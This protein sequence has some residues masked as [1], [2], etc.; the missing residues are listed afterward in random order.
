MRSK[1]VFTNEKVKESFERL[2]D[3]RTGDRN[4]HGWLNRAF[5]DLAKDA[6]CGI[7]IPKKRVQT[8]AILAQV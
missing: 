6:F 3:S 2:K 1:V 4:I 5:D 8:H 7:Q